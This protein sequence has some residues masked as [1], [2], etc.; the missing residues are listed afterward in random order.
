MADRRWRFG[1]RV[2][3]R[4]GRGRHHDIRT[5]SADGDGMTQALLL[6]MMVA[7]AVSAAPV[8][9]SR[10]GLPA[11]GPRGAGFD[12]ARTTTRRT[13]D[14]RQRG[15][16]ATGSVP[17]HGVRR[18]HPICAPNHAGGSGPYPACMVGAARRLCRHGVHDGVVRRS[19]GRLVERT[20]ADR[21]VSP[22]TRFAGWAMRG[23]DDHADRTAARGEWAT[24]PDR[25]QHHVCQRGSPGV[26]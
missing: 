9:F 10:E 4:P 12:C 6:G 5:G 18:C 11:V 17:E 25:N 7:T 22:S 26:V 8:A 16:S 23:D 15:S 19:D 21:S 20:R 24:R 1:R 3:C 2:A 13:A 14:L